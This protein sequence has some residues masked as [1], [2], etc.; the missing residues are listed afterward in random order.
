MRACGNWPGY[1]PWRTLQLV[2]TDVTDAGLKHLETLHG[3]KR[4]LLRGTKT[5][6]EGRAALQKA[7]PNCRVPISSRRVLETSAS[8]RWVSG[9]DSSVD[10]MD[11][12][13]SPC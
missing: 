13:A 11:V 4:I 1:S 8:H 9:I 3:L 7:L 12:F 10:C 6:R 2:N 5:T